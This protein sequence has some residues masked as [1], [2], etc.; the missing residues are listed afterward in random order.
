MNLQN[1]GR[2]F[3]DYYNEKEDTNYTPFEFFDKKVWPL[4][5]DNLYHKHLYQITNSLFSQPH[6][7]NQQDFKDKSKRN[8]IK[9]NFYKQIKLNTV[10]SK[11]MIGGCADELEANS[12]YNIP[13]DINFEY[14]E[15]ERYL[16]WIAYPLGFNV[17]EFN[18][19]INDSEIMYKLFKSHFRYKELLNSPE[20]EKCKG[21]KIFSWN[22]CFF[23]LY[24]EDEDFNIFEFNPFENADI[25]NDNN[26]NGKGLKIIE[27][28]SNDKDWL[29]LFY[30]LS[31]IKSNQVFN[32]NVVSY[33]QTAKNIGFFKIKFG[34]FKKFI[35]ICK[36]FFGE[37]DYVKNINIYKNFI[38]N[39]ESPK[40]ILLGGQL[41]IVPLKPN[42]Y[43]YEHINLK[44][45]ISDNTKYKKINYV[46]QLFKLFYGMKT[47]TNETFQ[48]MEK[49]GEDL[50]NLDK[51]YKINNQIDY[52]IKN[53]LFK[54]KNKKDFIA[55]LG[56][57]SNILDEK[58]MEQPNFLKNM[59]KY[60]SEISSRNEFIE[61][62][63]LININFN[64]KKQ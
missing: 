4:Y 36:N 52:L 45:I 58:N 26:N 2:K 34:E 20:Y 25:K 7:K 53:N 12:S 3:L 41:G 57:I 59:S 16:S 28:N 5:F 31:K 30:N 8:E 17:G 48:I 54:S 33:V 56:E 24:V 15:E 49:W 32:C 39:S 19:Y 40:N 13:L 35:D 64:H 63:V 22:T 14:T 60:F 10:F 21:Y 47:Q 44:D 62:R 51:E 37:N 9:N 27:F 38:F 50:F 42:L 6:E 11:I 61:A 1:Y 29:R 18:L 43:V 55:T 46:K 23:N